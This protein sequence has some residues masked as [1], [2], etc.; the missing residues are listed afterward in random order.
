MLWPL[1]CGRTLLND[2]YTVGSLETDSHGTPTVLRADR[3]RGELLNAN[4]AQAAPA[5]P[6]QHL[7]S[8]VGYGR[9][10]LEHRPLA[11][12]V[13]WRGSQPPSD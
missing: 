5:K 11:A 13:D 3:D 10:V 9:A 7:G 1:R 2:I 6:P 4:G 8:P 12:D